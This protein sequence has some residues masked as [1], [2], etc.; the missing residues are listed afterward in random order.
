MPE[1]LRSYLCHELVW[2][3]VCATTVFSQAVPTAI[4]RGTVVDDSTS[5]VLENADVFISQTTLGSATDKHGRFEIRNV[6]LGSYE[7]VASRVGY[8][9]RSM[10]VVVGQSNPE[11]LVVAL[12]PKSI[13]M[14]EVAV[15]ATEAREW[16]IQLE[17]F[18]KLFFGESEIASEAKL[19]NPEI[20]DFTGNANPDF[21][22]TA[23]MPLEIDNLALGYH[24]Q[25]ML[26]RFVV[27]KTNPGSGEV[28][29]NQQYLNCVG[30][31]KFIELT[32][33]SIEDGARW[34]A[35]RMLAYRGS[36]RHF[37]VSLFRCELAREGFM[38]WLLP[39]QTSSFWN[40]GSVESI[41]E[42]DILSEGTVPYEKTLHFTGTLVVKY[43]GKPVSAQKHL[44]DA[45]IPAVDVSRVRL[46]YESV[47]IT[48]QGVIEDWAPTRLYGYWAASRIAD[49]LPLDYKPDELASSKKDI[50]P[51][52]PP[53]TSTQIIPLAVGNQWTTR[54][55]LRNGEGKLISSSIQTSQIISDTTIDGERWFVMHTPASGDNPSRTSLGTNRPDG[56]YT[57]RS[58]V[59][60][61][62]VKYPVDVGDHFQGPNGET[63]VL[64]TNEKVSVPK[65]T[66]VCYQYSVIL[67]GPAMARATT[68]YSPGVGMVSADAV[69]LGANNV[70]T[71][72]TNTVELLD[73]ILH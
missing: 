58:G 73:Y 55:S 22:A 64:S 26:T 23:R 63:K 32:P 8:Q 28:F 34:N 15:T 41:V 65:G 44:L 25:F 51:A 38:I 16:K 60:S 42:N 6:P 40:P 21:E 27:N 43:V 39:Q 56:F 13:E 68:C 18:K 11:Q 14:N 46:N 50:N 4:L 33:T 12:R 2:L 36:F 9:M 1:T 59:P 5:M 70:S 17:K 37:L 10:R 30:K 53:T 47:R 57:L 48:S 71:A 66:F 61:L 3:L 72:Y 24:L 7:L 35:N 49:A 54:T 45:A 20:L 67:R 62:L 69:T 29:N 19:L 31:E 52:T